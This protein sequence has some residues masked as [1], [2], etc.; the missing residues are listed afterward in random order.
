ME[1]AW[2][3]FKMAS[4][5]VLISGIGIAG[6]TLAY[7]LAQY[8]FTVT[9]VDRAPAMRTG[10][11]VIDFWGLGYDIAD[12]MGLAPEIDRVGYHM[13]ELRMVGDRGQRL[14]GFGTR[15]FSELT[16]GRFATLPRSDLSR[17]IFRTIES[18]TD[19]LF[20]DEIVCLREESER[21]SVAFQHA[22]ERHFDLVIGADGLHSRVRRLAFG[23]QERF[24][25]HL[26]YTAAA[27]EATGYLPR[28]EQVYVVYGLPGRQLARFALRGDRTLFLFVFANDHPQPADPDS[29]EEQKA[30][31]RERFR[32]GGWECQRILD[33]LGRAP[34]LYFD[35]VSQIR[36]DHWSQGRVALVGDAAA[37]VSLLGGQGSA[38]AMTC[39]YVLAGELRRANGR[40]EVAFSNYERRLRSFIASKQ[41]SAGRFVRS[42]APRT[43]HGLVLRNAVL[44]AFRIPGLARLTLGRDLTDRLTL[45]DYSASVD[46]ATIS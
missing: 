41:N 24:E 39:A 34:D 35:R 38:L 36:M 21:V 18:S 10:G 44:N 8:G 37:C 29:I 40:H 28:D 12:R 14:A 1:P 45:P 33:E 6:P 13:R 2:Y 3:Q 9:L 7:W 11:Y 27:F 16:G 4:Q 43:R 42:F 19:I 32:D 20:N 31:L 46:R 15:V 23:N 5:H 22:S 25:K 17:L 26:G 30:L